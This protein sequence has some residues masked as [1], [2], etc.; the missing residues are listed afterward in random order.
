[1][2]HCGLVHPKH[3]SYLCFR[4][5]RHLHKGSGGP[6]KTASDPFSRIHHLSHLHQSLYLHTLTTRNGI[7]FVRSSSVASAYLLN[8][9]LEQLNALEDQL[10]AERKKVKDL[11]RQDSDVLK[12]WQVLP[13]VLSVD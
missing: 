5:R 4:N 1:M 11:S 10:V 8:A 12:K 2:T 7:W 3:I 9:A 6:I 13:H